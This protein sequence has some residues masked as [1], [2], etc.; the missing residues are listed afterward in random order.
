[1]ST[2][3]LYLDITSTNFELNSEILS[4]LYKLK[5]LEELILYQKTVAN[6]TDIADL[7]DQL[8][9]LRKLSAGTFIFRITM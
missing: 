4:S 9:S 5:N 6:G 2:S 3:L 1:M 8:P 7:V